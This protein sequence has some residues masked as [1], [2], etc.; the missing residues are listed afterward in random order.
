MMKRSIGH[1][2][3][4]SE[5]IFWRKG[6]L[7][8]RNFL[9]MMIATLG[10]LP[11][12]IGF[13]GYYISGDITHQLLPFVYETKRM[14]ASGTPFWSWNTYFGDNFIASYA[15]YTV[16]NPFMWL[17]CLFPYKY[18]GIGFTLVLYLK[19]L[20]C[21]YAAQKYLKKMGFGEGLSLMGCL[22]YTFSSWAVSNLLFY[23][24][25]EPMILF[26]F[27]LIFVE[28]FLRKDKH[29]YTGLV[30]ATFVVVAVNYYFA[31][32]N[33][34]AAAIYFFCRL[35]Y[36]K[37]SGKAARS[38]IAPWLEISKAAGCVLLGIICASVVLFP[39]LYQLRG[40]SDIPVDS[41]ST[42]LYMWI[43]RLFWLVYPKAH[44]GRFFY[45]FLNS[46]WK[47]NT[48]SIAV[49]GLLP[50]VLL[51]TKKGFGW[52][53]WLTALMLIIYVTPLNG[54]FSL[55][56]DWY[57][58]RW[59]YALTLAIILCTLYY[60]KE[61]GM[62]KFRY[63]VWYCVAVYG[64][65]FIFAGASAYWYYRVMG[66]LASD[67]ITGLAMDATLVAVN[68]IALITLCRI[69]SRK[70]NGLSACII[71]ITICTSM[72]F[73]TYSLPGVRKSPSRDSDITETDYFNQ[74]FDFR[75]DGEF[76]YRTNFTP[77]RTG[78][79]PSSNFG[80]ISN[81]PSIETYHSVQ[82]GKIHKWNSVVGDS[83][84]Q[85]RVFFPRKFVKSFEAFMSVKDLVILSHT[86]TDTMSLG[87]PKGIKDIFTIY[88][89]DHYI[90]MG[91]SYDRYVISD[92]I[93]AIAQQDGNIDIP[94]V[95]LSAI[96]IDREDEKELSRYLKKGRI[97]STL[98][99][100]SLVNERRSVTCDS[101]IGH[102]RGI[103]AH[104]TLDSMRLV[105]FSV[106]SDPGFTAY[107]DGNS[108]KIYETNLGLSS[109]IVPAGS[110]DIAFRYFPPG[111]KLG[112]IFTLIG[113]S[114]MG[115]MF[116][117]RL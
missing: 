31:A 40:Y 67:A 84:H 93:E 90:P 82:N 100:D 46:G 59:A 23:F 57:Y 96:A 43:D 54:L 30:L 4:D 62:P 7:T 73:L 78:G 26:P 6:I 76:S 47:S 87:K 53:K 86:P 9:I 102:S 25:L 115:L 27:L 29:P 117:K 92:E 21:G 77:V 56:T 38:T 3:G 15:Y 42:D 112:L 101:F 61:Y 35:F 80:L 70:S 88:E 24:F 95:L 104:I 20:V 106:L 79:R 18:L 64:F 99:L 50:A 32:V 94:K 105:F 10:M 22:L 1:N 108:T 2:T 51:F 13:G 45:L 113:L 44:E 69:V 14:F 75:T 111:L 116:S 85:Q 74:R 33:L 83:I 60:L 8:N 103:D 97:D 89:S 16:F 65:F 66:T 36:I 58:T 109:V 55:F 63:A 41:D 71:A 68:A 49:F 72:Q 11:E 12:L 81:R 52:I 48:A 39:V 110:H 107:I 114:A 34:I 19:F 17:N 37:G 98:S 28:R 5:T 91:F